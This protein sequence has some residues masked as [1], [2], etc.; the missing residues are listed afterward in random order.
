MEMS[1][2]WAVNLFSSW[3]KRRNITVEGSQRLCPKNILQCDDHKELCS[4]LCIC[5]I[6]LQNV[7]RN[8]HTPRSIANFVAGLQRYISE[9][10]S[11][12]VHCL[13]LF[14][15]FIYHYDQPCFCFVYFL[16]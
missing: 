8:S 4:W 5:V 6:E 15:D 16:H 14:C 11:V 1:T 10:K 9:Q 7:D 13:S 2:R 3:M 12:S